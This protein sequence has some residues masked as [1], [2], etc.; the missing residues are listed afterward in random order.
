MKDFEKDIQDKY[1]IDF[2]VMKKIIGLQNTNFSKID[3]IEEVKHN[4]NEK[5]NDIMDYYIYLHNKPKKN[6]YNMKLKNKI[7]LKIY[8]LFR[9]VRIVRRV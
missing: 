6:I 9:L 5:T 7:K 1:F 4:Y 8:R 3:L 2:E